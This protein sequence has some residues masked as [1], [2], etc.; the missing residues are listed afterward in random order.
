MSYR[1]NKKVP[2]QRRRQRDPHHKQYVSLPFGGG[3]NK[4]D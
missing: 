3:H 4:G 2:R 1:A